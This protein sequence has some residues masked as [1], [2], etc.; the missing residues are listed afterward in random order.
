MYPKLKENI[1]FKYQPNFTT[2][3][4][5]EKNEQLNSF[6]INKTAT[7]ILLKC[8]GVNSINDI[9][10]FFTHVHNEKPEVVS[11]FVD[12]FLEQAINANLISMYDYKSTEIMKINTNGSSSYWTPKVIL[13]ELTKDCPL[14]CK[15][16]YANA[17][18]GD[19][20]SYELLMKIC[21][22]SIKLGIDNIR[23]T[24]GEPFLYKDLDKIVNYLC[25]N[26][27]RIDIYTSGVINTEYVYNIIEKLNNVNGSLQ[28]SIDGL[29]ET[30]EK[31]RGINGC[32]DKSIEFIKRAKELNAKI[33]VA[34]SII[35]QNFEEI[36]QLIKLL[37]SIKVDKVRLG[38]VSNQGR[39]KDNF[40]LLSYK[41]NINIDLWRKKLSTKYSDS[42]FSI[43]IS[44]EST[45]KKRENIDT[46]CGMGYELLKISPNGFIFPCI[47]SEDSIWDLNKSTIKNYL[48]SKS[49]LFSSLKKPTKIY[50]ENCENE[51]ICRK[52]IIQGIMMHKE[53]YLCKWYESQS[54]LLKQLLNPYIS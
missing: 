10:S 54:E 27:V 48:L 41:D 8:D 33:A 20:I 13:I 47:L 28:V 6:N 7:E 39:S 18:S 15:H 2:I 40:G 53:N 21:K 50:C 5:S 16:C 17:G 1:K 43:E 23:F 19:S 31:I 42:T 22:E 34:V 44:E 35:N 4:K 14:K 9:K 52:C 32:F 26:N 11:E 29:K 49:N 38:L 46:S 30:H 25:D 51:S 24:G 36:D 3:I 37:K 12:N 45:I